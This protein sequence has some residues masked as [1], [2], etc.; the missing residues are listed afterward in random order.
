[1]K[2]RLMLITT[3]LISALMVIN[4]QS[5]RDLKAMYNSQYSYELM[6]LG[7]GQ[8]GTKA[9]KVWSYGKTAEIAAY[10][11]KRDAVAAVIFKGVPGGNGAA[12][13]PPILGIDGYEKN[14]A[15]FDE[16]FKA[17]G[18][19]LGFINL[20]NDGVPSGADRIKMDKGFKVAIY[21]SVNFDAL[22]KYLED[23]GIARR[24]DAGF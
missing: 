20:T 12:P 8:D 9:I 18:M 6:T 14:E 10:N 7:V 19:Y 5:R 15:F 23:K 22:R 11:A 4:A 13:T 1:M 24:L 21:A 17:G 16:F 3:L 2:K